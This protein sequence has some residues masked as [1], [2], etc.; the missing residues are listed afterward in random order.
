MNN[1]QIITSIL[2]NYPDNSFCF[3]SRE[4]FINALVSGTNVARYLGI[5]DYR[6]TKQVKIL[7][8][9]KG[10]GRLLNYVLSLGNYKNCTKCKN[11]LKLSNFRLNRRNLDG[12]NSFCNTCHS[13]TTA[14][15]QASRQA[16]YRSNKIKSTPPWANK[17][18]IKRIYADCPSGY[19]VDHIYPLNGVNT[20]GLHVENNLQYLTAKENCSKGNKLPEDYC[21]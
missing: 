3:I 16:K 2:D 13:K 15:T 20:C 11:F 9:E 5:S 17:E 21:S 18:K 7:F 8:P 10:K 4:D 19:H 12:V 14:L 6:L 1:K